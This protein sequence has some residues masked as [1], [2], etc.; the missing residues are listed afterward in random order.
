MKLDQLELESLEQE[1]EEKA[2][3]KVQTAFDLSCAFL[4]NKIWLFFSDHNLHHSSCSRF[5]DAFD[6]N[7]Q[8]GSLKMTRHQKRKIDE[9]HVEEVSNQQFWESTF[10]LVL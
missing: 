2:D 6:L 8:A 7:L 10:A 4:C 3:D 9:T 5:H 1:G